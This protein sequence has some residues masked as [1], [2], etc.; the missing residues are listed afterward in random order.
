MTTHFSIQ[1]PVFEPDLLI[2]PVLHRSEGPYG[3]LLRL[4]EANGMST[5]M[6]HKLGGGFDMAWLARNRLVPDQYQQPELYQHAAWIGYLLRE[7]KEIWNHRHARYCP[8]CL[9]DEPVWKTGWELIFHDACS[10]HGTWLIDHCSDCNSPIGWARDHL[11]SCQCGADLRHAVATLAPTSVVQLA[12]AIERR[13]LKQPVL[14]EPAPLIGLEIEHIQRLVRYLGFRMNPMAGLKSVKML[15][16]YSMQTSW[17]VSSLAAEILAQWPNAFYVC[18]SRLQSFS[19]H[20]KAGLSAVLKQAY[21]YLYKRLDDEKFDPIRVAFEMWVLEEWQGGISRRNRR[22]KEKVLSAAK[23]I[24]ARQA[25]Y[26]LSV[27]VSR[28]KSLVSDGYIEGKEFV[29]ERGRHFL[30]VRRDRLDQIA[31]VVEDEITLDAA[32]TMLGIGKLRTRAILLRILPS[33]SRVSEHAAWRVSKQEVNAIM[34]AAGRLPIVREPKT[35]QVPLARVLKAWRWETEAVALL[36][37]AV[38]EKKLMP[39]SRLSGESGITGWI[40][41]SGELRNWHAELSSPSREWLTIAEVAKLL[42]IHEESAYWLA[43]NRYL[44]CEDVGVKKRHVYQVSPKAIEDMKSRVVF[45]TELARILGQGSGKIIKMLSV[46]G[47]RQLRPRNTAS[48]CRQAV[49]PRC[50]EI[51]LLLNEVAGTRPAKLVLTGGTASSKRV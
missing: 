14:A 35:Y 44:E 24:S 21:Y 33:S 39:V 11:L 17:P 31:S 34:A 49:Y 3:Y 1:E 5:R 25:A 32:M 8:L 2:R 41:D 4:A 13:V 48:H 15:N 28:L 43:R 6:L 7:K 12:L 20:E 22:L 10:Q 29:S 23:W 38:K 47:I 30:M 18:W 51:E 19:S 42:Y 50:E 40:F 45:A 27:S 16:A 46:R 37:E 26:E 9:S 36:I